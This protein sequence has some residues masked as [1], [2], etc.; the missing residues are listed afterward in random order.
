MLSII[1]LLIS[2]L[3]HFIF[4]IYS[5]IH[6]E[7][8]DYIAKNIRLE[9]KYLGYFLPFM[10]LIKNKN[11]LFTLITSGK[12]KIAIKNHYGE[13]IYEDF[14]LLHQA[15]KLM[16]FY[17]S[18]IL[19]II[20]FSLS[21]EKI[22]ILIYPIFVGVFLYYLDQ[23]E[24]KKYLKI[25]S[26]MK[27]DL[28]NFVSRLSLMLESGINLRDSLNY[29]VEKSNDGISQNIAEVL[30]MVKNG[31][32]EEEAFNSISIKN[33]DILIRKFISSI[34]QNFKTGSD[35]INQSLTLIKKETNE[36]RKTQ[37]ILESQEVNRKLL[38]PNIVIFVGIM[39][40][41]MLPVLLN[42]L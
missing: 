16:F 18:S 42:T 5:Y 41:V 29:I 23:I 26:K 15:K 1:L 4:L 27:S 9:S 32:S 35:D 28:P 3:I 19:F 30:T 36:Y 12:L 2:V 7:E 24:I 39:L 20:T 17:Y 33:E 34:V 40:T 21:T 13:N 10:L 31:M 25:Q 8:I 37:V 22:L 11:E 38:I 6:R 14:L